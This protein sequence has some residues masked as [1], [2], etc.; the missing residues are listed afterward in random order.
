MGLVHRWENP[1]WDVPNRSGT[2]R[3]TIGDLVYRAI[4]VSNVIQDEVESRHTGRSV[5]IGNDKSQ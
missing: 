2:G 1:H 5:E 4:G 3:N